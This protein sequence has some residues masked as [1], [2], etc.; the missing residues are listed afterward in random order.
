MDLFSSRRWGLQEPK[1]K[2]V[3]FMLNRKNYATLACHNSIVVWLLGRSSCSSPTT[4][5]LH[6]WAHVTPIKATKVKSGVTKMAMPI[7]TLKPRFPIS[8]AIISIVWPLLKIEQIDGKWW[9]IFQ[10]PFVGQQCQWFTDCY[11][12]KECTIHSYCSK[13][14]NKISE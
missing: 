14:R 5:E 10:M 6:G 1:Q 4:K 7:N 8:M 13:S 12:G 11:L 3:V 9:N 2:A